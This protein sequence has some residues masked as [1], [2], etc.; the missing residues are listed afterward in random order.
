MCILGNC[1]QVR[2]QPVLL[3]YEETLEQGARDDLSTRQGF[4]FCYAIFF[5]VREMQ[6]MRH[7][8]PLFPAEHQ[9]VFTWKELPFEMVDITPAC[10]GNV[11]HV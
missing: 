9:Q 1:S 2:T 11:A 5:L 7:G 8:I 3:R 10:S 6:G 4:H